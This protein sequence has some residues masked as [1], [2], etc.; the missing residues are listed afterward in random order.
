M[1]VVKYFFPPAS[2]FAKSSKPFSASSKS[3]VSIKTSVV[4]SCRASKVTPK[5]LYQLKA[6]LFS[7]S[8][9]LKKTKA[10]M[11]LYFIPSTVSVPEMS[12]PENLF[13][14]AS[15]ALGATI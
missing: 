5:M 2:C 8:K 15:V 13:F 7:S 10:E 11:T 14:A 4:P 6:S 9:P 12:G 1:F 3:I